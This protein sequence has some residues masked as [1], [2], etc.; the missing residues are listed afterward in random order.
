M[1]SADVYISLRFS[2]ARDKAQLLD[3]ALRKRGINAVM[4]DPQ[5]RWDRCLFDSFLI[6]ICLIFVGTDMETSQG[7]WEDYSLQLI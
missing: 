4:A 2:E 7:K 5:S 1:A 3:E 6:I